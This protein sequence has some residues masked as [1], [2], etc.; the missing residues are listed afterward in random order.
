[1]RIQN[2]LLILLLAAN[3]TA[4]AQ[5]LNHRNAEL[6]RLSDGRPDLKAP[7]PITPDEKPD[8]S[9]IWMASP[10]PDGTLGGV[11]N[12]V[13]PKYFVSVTGGVSPGNLPMQPWAADLFR[14]RLSGLGKDH[15]AAA[16]KPEETPQRD[17]FPMPFKIV[18]TPRLVILLY[19]V[20]TVFRQVFLDG[21][22]LPDD[23]QPSWL[24]Y[25]VGRWEGDTLVV[26]T[27]GFR[28]QGWLDKIGHPHSDALHMTERFR[29]TDTGHMSIQV[30]LHDPKAYPSPISF[31]Q[32]HELLPDTDL[33]EYFCS[34]NEKDQLHLVGAL[35]T[36]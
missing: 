33:I 5:W 16:C 26:D 30:T 31:T 11:E 9:G 36:R 21:R 7:T 13:P 27:T 14:R 12:G 19:E 1:M 18:Q 15:P 23:P 4:T 22:S 35:E 2:R 32:A 10:D 20:D 24:G 17:A 8:L 25:S 34:D 29:R 6:P 28:D 3:I